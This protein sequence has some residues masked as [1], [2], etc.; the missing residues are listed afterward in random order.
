MRRFIALASAAAAL[1][2]GSSPAFALSDKDAYGVWKHPENG[3]LIR[4]YECGG[5][6]CA[7]IVQVAEAGRKDAKNPN[8]ALRDRPVV[9]VVIMQG[10]KKTGPQTWSGNLYNTL[11][12]ET[13]KGTLQLISETEMK[14]QGCVMGGLI[15]S[16]PTW[17]KVKN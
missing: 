3:S 15:C 11:D 9:G 1:Y 6:A 4:I 13:Y 8:P 12:G 16:G 7:K 14:L 10:G 2:I 17:T 5:G